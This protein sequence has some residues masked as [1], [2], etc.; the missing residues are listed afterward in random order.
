MLPVSYAEF[1]GSAPNMAVELTAYSVRCA[2]ASGSSSPRAFGAFCLTV[3]ECTCQTGG[4]ISS[5]NAT[6][7]EF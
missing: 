3:E 6:M 7:A 2:P 1:S 5:A 4:I